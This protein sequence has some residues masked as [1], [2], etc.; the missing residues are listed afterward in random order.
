MIIKKQLTI[1][2]KRQETRETMPMKEKALSGKSTTARKILAR[3]LPSSIP[4]RP[5]PACGILPFLQSSLQPENL[6]AKSGGAFEAKS[7]AELRDLRRQCEREANR[8]GPGPRSQDPEAKGLA[9]AR[10]N[11]FFEILEQV[12]A[13][14][15]FREQDRAA[16]EERAEQRAIAQAA[17]EE[18]R[19]ER[20]AKVEADKVAK[21][22]AREAG[23]VQE[24]V[25]E[26]DGAPTSR[27]A[28]VMNSVSLALEAYFRRTHIV[29]PPSVARERIEL[30][31]DHNGRYF[32]AFYTA[33]TD[34]LEVWIRVISGTPGSTSINGDECMP[35]GD[36]KLIHQAHIGEAKAR[37]RS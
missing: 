21:A 34:T 5:K 22:K 4:L 28:S 20:I 13:E 14:L 32:I 3:S 2:P 30:S 18:A 19:D 16:R 7:Y 35:A 8:S 17:R 24:S 23:A 10:S 36:N 6:M 27:D 26:R 9:L 33:A 31:W 11:R 37:K 25:S 15:R 12:T 1:M 29:H